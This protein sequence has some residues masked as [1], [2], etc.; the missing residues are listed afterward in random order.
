MA[1][2]IV[3]VVTLPDAHALALTDVIETTIE[4]AV[5][6]EREACAKIADEEADHPD[7]DSAACAAERIRARGTK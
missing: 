6:A 5:A 4:R 2:R 7:G 1:R 3:D